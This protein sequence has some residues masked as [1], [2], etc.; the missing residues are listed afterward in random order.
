MVI[1]LSTS[2]LL[3]CRGPFGGV[4][5]VLEWELFLLTS[6]SLEDEGGFAFTS[7]CVGISQV[8]MCR[9]ATLP[10]GQHEGAFR[11][12]ESI[13]LVRF[14]STSNAGV[15]VVTEGVTMSL[16]RKNVGGG[17]GVLLCSL[18]LLMDEH[19]SRVSQPFKLDD[20]CNNSSSELGLIWVLLLQMKVS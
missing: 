3:K 20:P 8:G 1:V 5:R 4:T 2:W 15:G 14:F 10:Q 6:M 16:S 13:M 11:W 9:C 12:R 19:S 17:G 18:T 7:A